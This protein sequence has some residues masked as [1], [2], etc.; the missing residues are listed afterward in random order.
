MILRRFVVQELVGG[1]WITL[2][3]ITCPDK[4]ATHLKQLRSIAP[5]QKPGERYRIIRE[6]EPGDY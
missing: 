1:R 3:K 2:A 5:E 6:G 4:T